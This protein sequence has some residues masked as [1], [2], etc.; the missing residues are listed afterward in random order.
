MQFSVGGKLLRQPNATLSESSLAP[1]SQ[2]TCEHVPLF[3]GMKLDEIKKAA[4]KK[5]IFNE[6]EGTTPREPTSGGL[7]DALRRRLSLNVSSTVKREEINKM[8]LDFAQF[9]ELNTKIKEGGS[10][11]EIEEQFRPMARKYV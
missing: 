3:G 9:E 10:T 2:V 4:G 7:G 1:Y 11:D 5:V 6:E 8:T